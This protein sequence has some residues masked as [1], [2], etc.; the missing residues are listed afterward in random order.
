MF[1]SLF[2]ALTRNQDPASRFRTAPVLWGAF[3]LA[4]LIYIR[5]G[6]LILETGQRQFAGLPSWIFTVVGVIILLEIGC[7]V[8]LRTLV[9]DQSLFKEISKESS[10]HYRVA[11]NRALLA[12]PLTERGGQAIYIAWLEL[13]IVQWAFGTSFAI[14]GLALFL[15]AGNMNYLYFFALVG[16]LDLLVLYPRKQPILDQIERWKQFQSTHMV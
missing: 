13:Y 15:L 8:Y 7:Q 2:K 10:R 1:S 9:S 12:L 6:R 3:L 5:L 14:Y 11:R 16:F 4:V